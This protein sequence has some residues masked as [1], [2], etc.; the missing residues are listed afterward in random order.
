MAVI[1]STES[2]VSSR[3][4]KDGHLI[5]PRLCFIVLQGIAEEQSE[6]RGL[7]GHTY[8]DLTKKGSY[9]GTVVVASISFAGHLTDKMSVPQ[10]ILL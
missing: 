6:A 9:S 3:F 8:C 1:D 5:C 2:Q 4:A 7:D 10:S